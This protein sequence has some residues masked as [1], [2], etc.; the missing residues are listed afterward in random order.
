MATCLL[1][2]QR[3]AFTESA[4]MQSLAVLCFEHML[5]HC[6]M[7]WHMYGFKK[8]WPQALT[9]GPD[10]VLSCCAGCWCDAFCG[11]AGDCCEDCAQSCSAGTCP[12]RQRTPASG[13][14]DPVPV[15]RVFKLPAN[16]ARRFTS[17]GYML[18]A[19]QACA[20]AIEALLPHAVP[21]IRVPTVYVS[22]S[23]AGQGGV[24]NASLAPLI[25]DG[26]NA[27]FARAGFA[28]D[29]VS[30][31]TYEFTDLDAVNPFEQC[32]LESRRPAAHVALH[33]SR[34][35]SLC[36]QAIQQ[37]L[38]AFEGSQGCMSKRLSHP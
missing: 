29:L 22:A 36:S 6:H 34:P 3:H 31:Y 33:T 14:S 20:D 27:A 13:P 8:P 37:H 23:I 10:I 38:F 19:E 25:I 16:M 5:W 12:R 2:M 15:D 11:A 32:F 18:E 17:Y 24:F 26:L 7:M 1:D 4:R 35:L 9:S 21:K 28:F 30:Q